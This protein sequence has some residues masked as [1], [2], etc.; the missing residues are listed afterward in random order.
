MKNLL[1]I[2]L[3]VFGVGALIWWLWSGKGVETPPTAPVVQQQVQTPEPQPRE[4]QPSKASQKRAQVV[5]DPYKGLIIEKL[6]GKDINLVVTPNP[7]KDATVMDGILT[8]SEKIDD[9]WSFRA[10]QLDEYVQKYMR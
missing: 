5:I 9:Q 6:D 10:L 1:V 7:T 8:Y 4:V 2:L 3:L